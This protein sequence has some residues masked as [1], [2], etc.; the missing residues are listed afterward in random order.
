MDR[1]TVWVWVW[2]T[3]GSVWV[4]LIGGSVELVANVVY[5]G[6]VVNGGCDTWWKVY[7]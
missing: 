1:A 4:S 2:V 6:W 5:V 7:Y 3:E